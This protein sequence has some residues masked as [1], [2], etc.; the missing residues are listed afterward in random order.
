MNTD[1]DSKWE[2]RYAA[3]PKPMKVA[4]Y[5][6]MIIGLLVHLFA[7]TNIIPN[8][9]GLSRVYDTQQMTISGR[10]FLHYASMIHG[11]IQAPSLIGVLSLLFLGLS[12]SMV[13]DLIKLR[14]T[15]SAIACGAFLAVFPSMAYTYLYMFTASAYTFGIFLAVLSVWIFRKYPHGQ[16]L[17]AVFLACAIGTYQAYFAVAVSIGLVCVILDLLDPDQQLDQVVK[18]GFRMLGMMLLGAVLYYLALQAFL[19]IKDLSLLNYRGIGAIGGSF[20]F[21]SLLHSLLSTYKQLI[22]YFLV[23]Y[24]ASYNTIVLTAAHWVFLLCMATALIHL[25][26]ARKH[27]GNCGRFLLLMLAFTLTP[28]AF[29]FT[30]LLSDSSPNMRYSFVFVYILALSILDGVSFKREKITSIVKTA[31]CICCSLIIL[32]S[33]QITNLAY[34]SSAT[35]HRATNAFAANLV[36]RV[37]Q[38]PG[39]SSDMEVVIIGTF[40]RKIYHSSIDAFSMVEH[41]SCMSDT[42]MLLNK[43]VYYYLNNWLNVPWA[44]PDE[45]TLIAISDSERFQQMPLYP[46]DG[47]VVIDNHQVIVKLAPRYVPKRPYEVEY[48]MR[49]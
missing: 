27:T 22:F 25:L 47:S 46:D 23:P 17:A 6:C 21:G 28:M 12:A 4:F 19:H 39:Y 8:S 29:N 1:H 20:S 13:T 32:I 3:I 37:E 15:S 33:A 40:P 5:S 14:K 26:K 36:S 34:T 11:Y 44:E 10:W 35:A 7:F 24:S 45:N 16:I 9:D 41:Y 38:T 18:N 42:V 49:R 31:T 43:H 30:Q 2:Q 48:E